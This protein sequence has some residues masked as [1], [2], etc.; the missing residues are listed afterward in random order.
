[1]RCDGR[2]VHDSLAH[3]QRPEREQERAGG[4]SWSVPKAWSPEKASR[5]L[6][7]RYVWCREAELRVDGMQ[8]R[9]MTRRLGN[10]VDVPCVHTTRGG[11]PSGH[12]TA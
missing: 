10:R 2:V 1:M 7:W 5:A 11:V 12:V 4:M 9:V 3:R 8:G 6:G